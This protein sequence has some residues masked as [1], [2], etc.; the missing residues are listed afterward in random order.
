M[1]K[2]TVAAALALILIAAEPAFAGPKQDQIAVLIISMT[3]VPLAL[4]PI[5]FAIHMV[6]A[7]LAPLRSEGLSLDLQDHYWK[8]LLLGLTN[9]AALFILAGVLGKR[10]P[11]LGGLF[12]LTFLAFAI[13]GLHG[14]VRSLGDWILERCARVGPAPS[15][16]KSLALGWFVFLYVTCIPI[17]G[18]VMGCYWITRGMGGVVLQLAGRGKHHD[19][20]VIKINL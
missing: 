10:A 2:A 1:A 20:G 9:F 12:S 17:L 8:T 7:S 16:M 13:L 4:F 18:W 5:G 14:I 3:L 19:I 11:A 6:L 15:P